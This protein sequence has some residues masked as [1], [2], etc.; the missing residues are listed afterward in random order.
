[1]ISEILAKAVHDEEGNTHTVEIHPH[2]DHLY[3]VKNMIKEN[4]GDVHISKIKKMGLS[5]KILD[6]IPRNN[7]G[8]VKT[9]DIDKHIESLPKTKVN[10][11]VVPYSGFAGEQ[12]HRMGN[13]QY[14]LV[15]TMHPEEKEKM[16][17]TLQAMWNKAKYKQHRVDPDHGSISRS[18]QIGWVRVDPHHNKEGDQ[19]PHNHWHLD[20]IQSDFQTPNKVRNAVS[21]YV[22]GGE[23]PNAYAQTH[24][25]YYNVSDELQQAAMDDPDH[26]LAQAWE[27]MSDE[28]KDDPNNEEAHDI[29]QDHVA[30]AIKERYPEHF[31]DAETN[32]AALLNHLSMGHD[33]PQHALHSIANQMGRKLGVE[34]TSMDMPDDQATKSVLRTGVRG[35]PRRRTWFP[36][37]NENSFR[38]NHID[39]GLMSSDETKDKVWEDHSK[40]IVKG[41]SQDEDF[42]SAVDKIGGLNSLRDFAETA[43]HQTSGDLFHGEAGDWKNNTEHVKHLHESF[44]KLDEEEKNML[45]TFLMQYHSKVRDAVPEEHIDRA[46]NSHNEVMQQEADEQYE[47]EMEEFRASG[48]QGVKE[49]PP[50]HQINTYKKRPKKLG[51]KPVDKKELLGDVG[52]Q[53]K[54]KEVQYSKLYKNLKAIRD[55]LKEMK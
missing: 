42:R 21:S 35:E 49:K 46:R 30:Q 17:P 48:G 37:F 28:D 22:F 52:P 11:K 9:E 1:M 15:A 47:R 2:I 10:V 27:N 53:E 32:H 25:E 19:K 16:N 29:L 50:V 13:D 44:D 38:D 41:L 43:H 36:P 34:S 6:D 3:R 54:A 26:P 24:P 55:L 18:D 14:T 51:M 7:K 39:S 23:N 8:R 12:K 45:S 20:E 4:D 31:Q 40:D 33:D 5:P